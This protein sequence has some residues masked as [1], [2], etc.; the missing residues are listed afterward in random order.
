[1]LRKF[2][3]TKIICKR[4]YSIAQSKNQRK[5]VWKMIAW[6]KVLESIPSLKET[7]LVQKQQMAQSASELQFAWVDSFKKIES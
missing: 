1:M 4:I 6:E 3:E 2:H 7:T 5:Q